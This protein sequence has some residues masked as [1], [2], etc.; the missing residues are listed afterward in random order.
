MT[1]IVY[2]PLALEDL[3]YIR[4]YITDS[5]GKDLANRIL[6]KI[7]SDI[8]RLEDYPL[9]GIDLGS[10]IDVRT[11]YRYLLSEKN[12]VFYHLELDEIRIIRILNEKQDYMQHLFGVDL[13]PE[14]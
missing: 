2:S 4:D 9:S 13:E 11:E 7:L 8:R 14:L 5:F 6:K 1:E 10:I 12:Y 3:S